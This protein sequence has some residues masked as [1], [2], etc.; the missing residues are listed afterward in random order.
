MTLLGL[1]TE[2]KK[3]NPLGVERNRLHLLLMPRCRILLTPGLCL[4]EE[5]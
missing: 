3:I 1:G 2:R 5:R 4:R